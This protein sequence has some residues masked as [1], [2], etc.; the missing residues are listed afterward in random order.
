MESPEATIT[1]QD[2]MAL[3]DV[4]TKVPPFLLKS[5]IARNTNL[6]QKFRPQIEGF[7]NDL[8]KEEILKIRKVIDMPVPVLQE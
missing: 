7:K 6:V 8:S 5:S 4:F 2:V 1:E 3:M